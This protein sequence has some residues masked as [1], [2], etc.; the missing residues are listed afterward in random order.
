MHY[1]LRRAQTVPSS[2]L[3]DVVYPP[4]VRAI[5]LALYSMSSTV[6]R[7]TSLLVSNVERVAR[8]ADDRRVSRTYAPGAMRRLTYT[9]NAPVTPS[10][11]TPSL[12]E[13]NARLLALLAKRAVEIT[14]LNKEVVSRRSLPYF[15]WTRPLTGPLSRRNPKSAQSTSFSSATTAPTL[16][17][18]PNRSRQPPSP[19]SSTRSSAATQSPPSPPHRPRLRR[20][21]TS[22]SM[23]LSE[24]FTRRVPSGARVWPS[25]QA[26][27]VLVV[28]QGID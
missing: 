17:L 23:R 20:R 13:E 22:L 4:T 18:P 25:G 2:Q 14:S 10:S 15:S 8:P 12:L 26:F 27:S 11:L 5:P 19:P 9:E 6:S 1:I 28:T 3:P 7:R 16:R 21:T 24:L